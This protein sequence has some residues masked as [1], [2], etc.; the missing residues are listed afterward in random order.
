MALICFIRNKLEREKQHFPILLEKVVYSGTHGGDWL[1]FETVLG[2][3]KEVTRISA[4]TV[5][6]PEEQHWI[7]EFLAKLIELIEAAKSVRKPISF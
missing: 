4:F 6:K 5:G 2:L 1:D 3:E 7:E